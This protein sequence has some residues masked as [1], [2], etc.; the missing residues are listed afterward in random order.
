MGALTIRG[1]LLRPKKWRSRIAVRLRWRSLWTI[2]GAFIGIPDSHLDAER[3]VKKVGDP[4]RSQITTS[5]L[6]VHDDHHAKPGFIAQHPL[7]ALGRFPQ[8]HGFDH[9][10]DTLENAE[11]KRVLVLAGGAG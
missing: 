3:I 11:S 4:Q 7:V 6:L 1:N 5:V 2:Y 9:G 10:F 8:R